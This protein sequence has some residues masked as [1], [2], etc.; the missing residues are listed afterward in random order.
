MTSFPFHDPSPELQS[1]N[2]LLGIRIDLCNRI[3]RFD[4]PYYIFCMRTRTGDGTRGLRIHHHT[5]PALV[6]LQDY[7]KRYLPLA[8]EGYGS[9]EDSLELNEAGGQDLHGLVERVRHDLVSWRLRQEAI[10]LLR[11]ELEV[12]LP[13]TTLSDD[14]PDDDDEKVDSDKEHSPEPVGRFG[15]RELSPVSVDARQARIIWADGR[16]GRLRIA[17]DGRIEKAVVIG[18]EDRLRD[19][20]RMLTD[21]NPMLRDLVWCLERVDQANSRQGNARDTRL[22]G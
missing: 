14:N 17:D 21:G 7:E 1:K 16:V 19:Q 9:S 2:P 4:S 5:I 18:Q 3:G 22:E 20:E 12:P 11:E 6:P 15:V 13:Q 8:D 10:E